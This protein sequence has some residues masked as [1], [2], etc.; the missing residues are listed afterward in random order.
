MINMVKVIRTQEEIAKE[1]AYAEKFT[2]ESPTTMFGDDNVHQL[3]I[4]EVI[5]R[6]ATED[7]D[8][9]DEIE[10][11]V[12]DAYGAS[13]NNSMRDHSFASDVLY[14]LTCKNSTTPYSGQ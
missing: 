9:E 6:K 8:S 1:T 2:E 11:F 3:H 14:W 13:D 12:N 4:F 7:M 5:I 10:Q